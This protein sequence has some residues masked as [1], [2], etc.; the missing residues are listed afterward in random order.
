MK[1]LLI[2]L[3][4]AVILLILIAFFLMSRGPDLSQFEPLREPRIITLPAQKMLA[5]EVAGDP[6]QTAGKAL[7][8]LFKT[9]FKI[10]EKTQGPVAPRARWPVS[11]DMPKSEWKGIYGMPVAE[12]VNE[13]PK[14]KAEPGLTLQL[15]TWEYG[16]VAE[17]LHVGTYSAETPTIEK[18]KKFI[19][20]N[21]YQIAGDHEEEYLKGPGMIFK[22][23]PNNYYTIIRYPVK[24]TSPD[25]TELS[26]SS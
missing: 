19:T 4:G 26:P 21:G 16:E 7:G 12:E 5:V 22:G 6:S 20:D 14:Y 10:K 13:L 2:I 9:Y 15:T 11:L 3:A 1:K 8:L 17:I 24:K 18:L 25:S 23:D